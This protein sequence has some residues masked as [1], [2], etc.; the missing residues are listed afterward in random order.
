MKKHKLPLSYPVSFLYLDQNNKPFGI[1]QWQSSEEN[2]TKLNV[3]HQTFL[4]CLFLVAAKEAALLSDSSPA[5]EFVIANPQRSCFVSIWLKQ[6]NGPGD[7]QKRGL[8]NN[9]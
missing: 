4:S 2:R 7:C 8:S 6:N 9:R 5:V 1:V 3:T